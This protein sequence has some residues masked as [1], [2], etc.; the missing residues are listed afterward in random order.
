MIRDT[1]SRRSITCRSEVRPLVAI[2]LAKGPRAID[3]HLRALAPLIDEG[4]FVPTVDHTVPPD[5]S[6]ANFRHYLARKDDL[7]RGRL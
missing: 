1:S 3:E 5:V 4:G 7:L 6:L 2:A